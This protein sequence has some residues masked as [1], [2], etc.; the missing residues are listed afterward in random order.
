MD[1]DMPAVG[2]RDILI[3]MKTVVICWGDINFHKWDSN[4]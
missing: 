1:F 3:K 2:T 4:F